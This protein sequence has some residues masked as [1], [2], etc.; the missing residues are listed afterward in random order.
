VPLNDVSNS[1]AKNLL[2]D[3]EKRI[4][5]NDVKSPVKAQDGEKP[6]WRKSLRRSSRRLTIP[7]LEERRGSDVRVFTGG[8]DFVLS[9]AAPM[10]TREEAT[11]LAQS[12]ANSL[13]ETVAILDQPIT[14]PEVAT[15]DDAT[16]VEPQVEEVPEP[17][18][19]ELS[20][21][22]E[23]ITSE[24]AETMD[25]TEDSIPETTDEVE[26]VI[27][28][29]ALS[30]GLP[31]NEQSMELVE[32]PEHLSVDSETSPEESTE[33]ESVSS[34]LHGQDEMSVDMIDDS[35]QQHTPLSNNLLVNETEV[36]SHLSDDPPEIEAPLQ[37]QEEHSPV[38][39]YTVQLSSAG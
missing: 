32:E 3:G 10:D 11:T 26:V 20:N 6:R 39:Q 9:P 4:P 2:Q 38:A 27:E 31:H 15:N 37:E 8:V 7:A 33:D 21:S 30:S 24:A 13:E 22:S 18:A 5:L 36:P 34:T 14:K 16:S 23:L 17:E 25:Y 19:V 29:K 35:E 28:D 1:P 12:E